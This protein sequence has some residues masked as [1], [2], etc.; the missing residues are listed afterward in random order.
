MLSTL[1]E[2]RR[3][4]IDLVAVRP[5]GQNYSKEEW[6]RGKDPAHP[7][8]WLTSKSNA[9]FAVKDKLCRIG[10]ISVVFDFVVLV[11]AQ[12]SELSIPTSSVSNV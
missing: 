11:A 1:G 5:Q 10:S 9:L 8:G 4:R 2:L 6:P 3:P 12:S 7:C